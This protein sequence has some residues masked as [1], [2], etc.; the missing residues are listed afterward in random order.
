MDDVMARP[1]VSYLRES[2]GGYPPRARAVCELQVHVDVDGD[3]AALRA[4]RVRRARHDVAVNE[5]SIDHSKPGVGFGHDACSIRSEPAHLG[6]VIRH[7]F[8]LVV[9]PLVLVL[10]VVARDARDKPDADAVCIG[11]AVGD[12][13]W[14]GIGDDVLAVD[15]VVAVGAQAVTGGHICTDAACPELLEVAPHRRVLNLRR[16][17]LWA[18]SM[19]FFHLI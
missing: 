19:L 4:E 8:V 11:G 18:I 15:D 7:R 3:D 13:L 17:N 5:R 6:V 2:S 12:V 9:L 10:G 16:R 14:V 1:V